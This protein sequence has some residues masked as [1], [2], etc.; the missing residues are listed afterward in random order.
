MANAGTVRPET[1]ADATESNFDVTSNANLRGVYFTVSLATPAWARWIDHPHRL[2]N[3]Q[4]VPLRR[5]EGWTAVVE[6]GRRN[7]SSA[8]FG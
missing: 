2:D 8:A 5:F 6:S 1:I 7:W 3:G 4:L